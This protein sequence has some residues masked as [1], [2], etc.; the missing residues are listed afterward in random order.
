M[1]LLNRKKT[2]RYSV[3]DRRIS[4]VELFAVLCNSNWAVFSSWMKISAC[5][6]VSNIS[7]IIE[8]CS[9]GC[10]CAF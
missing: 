6:D 7:D 4:E 8:L 2:T 1:D 5:I 9:D 3:G 10:Y